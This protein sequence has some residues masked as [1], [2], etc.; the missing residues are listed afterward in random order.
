M[1]TC[2]EIASSR[3]FPSPKE[4]PAHNWA[5]NHQFKVEA[6][7]FNK[8]QP[9]IKQQSAQLNLTTQLIWCISTSQ[10]ISF[11]S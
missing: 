2:N 4:E 7:P 9:K 3:S 10:P 8:A 1:G 6:K 5:H 11:P